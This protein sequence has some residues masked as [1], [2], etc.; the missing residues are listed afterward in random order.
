MRINTNVNSLT[1]Q[2][3]NSTTN[4]N[5]S[6][7][8]ERLS[9]GLRIN[10]AADDASGMA[11]ADSLRNQGN[12]LGQSIKNANDAIGI[13]QI[14]DK[15]MDEQLKILDTI[16]TKATQAAQDGQTSDSRKAIQ[17]DVDKLLKALDDIATT[18]SF[19]GQ[20]LLNGSYTNKEFQVGAYSQQT[21]GMS[22]MSTHSSKIGDVRFETGKRISTASDVTLTFS[23]TDGVN[24]ITLETVTISYAAGTGIGA[25]SDVINKNS[26][27]LGGINASWKVETIGTASITAGDVTGLKINSVT[28]GDVSAIESM[29]ADGRLVNAIN[30]VTDQTGV[31]AYTDARGRLNLRSLDGRGIAITGTGLASIS[32]LTENYG[33]LSLTRAG[34]KDIGLTATGTGFSAASER[35]INLATM[36]GSIGADDAS[37]IGT[38]AISTSDTTGNTIQPGVTTL[39]GAM[40]LMDIADAAIRQLDKIRGSIG[41]TQGQLEA[42]INN[43]SVTQVNVKAAES[44]IRDVDFAEESANFQKNNLLAQAGSYAMSQALQTPQQMIQRILL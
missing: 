18:T 40:A 15:A 13:V 32:G 22:I 28:I 20:S 24:D 17:A 37:A 27:K 2:V 11:I 26:D 41:S 42:T 39:S 8:L 21:V 33:R 43:T 10:K 25:L 36:K 19:N 31:E 29:D 16:K 38:N 30:E 4:R 1:S 44:Q 7:S 14:A 5:L 23:A 34:G 6:E 35:T 3:N 9:S 12:S